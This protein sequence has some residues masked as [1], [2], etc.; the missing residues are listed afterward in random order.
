M[1]RIILRISRNVREA[2]KFIDKIN[3]RIEFEILPV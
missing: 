1:G 3:P 2:E